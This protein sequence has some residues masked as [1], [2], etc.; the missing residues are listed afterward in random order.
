MD[1]GT[2]TNWLIRPASICVNSIDASMAN[3]VSSLFA[4]LLLCWCSLALACQFT[5]QQS[6]RKWSSASNG[7]Q[8]GELCVDL[9]RI[10]FKG[11]CQCYVLRKDLSSAAIRLECTHTNASILMADIDNLSNNC[12]LSLVELQVINSNLTRLYHLPSGLY[13]VQ[14]MVL[15]NTGID[16]ETIRESNELLKSLR[17]LRISNDNYT[18]VTVVAFMVD[19]CI[20]FIL[21]ADS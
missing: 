2:S 10:D 11:N 9:C 7:L 14:E 20:S 13:N 6:H 12:N 16:L 18:E 8:R 15:E 17:I 5:N 19:G 3:S 1:N 21:I 4:L